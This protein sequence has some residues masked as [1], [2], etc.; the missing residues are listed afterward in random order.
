M[1]TQLPPNVWVK[2]TLVLQALTH[3]LARLRRG[4]VSSSDAPESIDDMSKYESWAR[5][6][7]HRFKDQ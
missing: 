2:V 4:R 5:I 3:R 7:M 6:K 1:Y